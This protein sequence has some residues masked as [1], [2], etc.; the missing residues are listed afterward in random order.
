MQKEFSEPYWGLFHATV[1]VVL[2]MMQPG[3][4]CSTSTQLFRTI[5]FIS[6]YY[7]TFAVFMF[8]F[9]NWL[10]SKYRN[11]PFNLDICNTIVPLIL[12]FA[13][14]GFSYPWST[15]VWNQMIFLLQ[16]HQ[17]VDSSLTLYDMPVSFTSCAIHL[18]LC[19]H[20]T[21]HIITRRRVSSA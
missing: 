2:N 11:I 7:L 21:A 14:R 19:R 15:A 12:N 8:C 16:H 18:R 4:P 10:Q 17:K 1:C 5:I 3:L 6:H 9:P 20:F 13:F